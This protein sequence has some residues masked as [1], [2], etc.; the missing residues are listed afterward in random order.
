[1]SAFESLPI[2]SEHE[3]PNSRLIYLSDSSYLGSDSSLTQ[4]L[5]SHLDPD[6]ESQDHWSCFFGFFNEV[7]DSGIPIIEPT[8]IDERDSKILGKGANMIVTSGRWGNKAVAVKRVYH[9]VSTYENAREL[10]K[11]RVK[12]LNQEL[13]MLSFLPFRSHPNIVRLLAVS[14][15]MEESGLDVLGFRPMLVVELANL[16]YPTLKALIDSGRLGPYDLS[17]KGFL[18]SD[19]IAGLEHMHRNS[20]LHGDIKTSNIL[21]FPQEGLRLTAKLTDFG[22]C[23]DNLTARKAGGTPGFVGPEYYSNSEEVVTSTSFPVAIMA[24]DV[25]AFGLVASYILLGRELSIDQ[26]GNDLGGARPVIEKSLNDMYSLSFF[27]RSDDKTTDFL[28]QMGPSIDMKNNSTFSI[29]PKAREEAVSR[30]DS[31]SE[32]IPIQQNL[33]AVEM[34][35]EERKPHWMF[36]SISKDGSEFW[37]RCTEYLP[38]TVCCI[39]AA[40]LANHHHRLNSNELAFLLELDESQKRVAR[41]R[42]FSMSTAPWLWHNMRSGNNFRSIPES[43]QERTLT[44][45]YGEIMSVEG[46]L[47]VSPSVQLLSYMLDSSIYSE[48]RKGASLARSF[49]K[50]WEVVD[51]N[52]MLILLKMQVGAGSGPNSLSG[53]LQLALNAEGITL[54]VPSIQAEIKCFVG[55]AIFKILHPA[56]VHAVPDSS[57]EVLLLDMLRLY[58]QQPYV[59]AFRQRPRPVFPAG[60]PSELIMTAVE[61][62]CVRNDGE[63]FAILASLLQ[64]LKHLISNE[65]AINMFNFAAEEGSLKLIQA[66]AHPSLKQVFN[67]VAACKLACQIP[68]LFGHPQ[69]LGLIKNGLIAEPKGWMISTLVNF[70]R[71]TF[72]GS[73]D[74][75]QTH[76]HLGM[77]LRVL[78]EDYEK[79]ETLMRSDA[80]ASIEAIPKGSRLDTVP[81]TLILGLPA[82]HCAIVSNNNHGNVDARDWHGMTPFLYTIEGC[83]VQIASMLLEAG[84]NPV[85]P[86]FKGQNALH[87]AVRTGNISM[88]RFCLEDRRILEL[89][90]ERDNAG[91]TPLLTAVNQGHIDISKRLMDVGAHLICPDFLGITL[92]QMSVRLGDPA[93]TVLLLED[94]F[95]RNHELTK[96][97]C[98]VKNNLGRNVLHEIADIP[99]AP[100]SATESTSGGYWQLLIEWVLGM[101][102]GTVPENLLVPDVVGLA[103]LD[104][105]RLQEMQYL[106]SKLISDY[107]DSS[108]HCNITFIGDRSGSFAVLKSDPVRFTKEV[109]DNP[110]IFAQADFCCQVAYSYYD[111]LDINLSA[112][113][114]ADAVFAHGARHLARLS[115]GEYSRQLETI[116]AAFE[117]RCMAFEPSQV[118]GSPYDTI[119]TASKLEVC[120]STFLGRCSLL[121]FAQER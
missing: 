120:Q 106:E 64:T 118:E 3:L 90:N 101:F 44:K 31:M 19:I 89:I 57:Y 70:V 50:K 59:A 30:L 65:D 66:L 98:R 56:M 38:A 104:I 103:P 14:W 39:P 15:E 74:H 53:V 40:L 61:L 2:A 21:I 82:L 63:S 76:S 22:S 51:A 72:F 8:S 83:E 20:I 48:R 36:R 47:D 29:F 88:V 43:M 95:N 87:I 11:A 68:A 28:G 96:Y 5:K 1:M 23:N 121:G 91:F 111:I 26:L 27:G 17:L 24:R 52:R 13:K 78:E 80:L 71:F 94:L 62:Q 73:R 6:S 35:Q 102:E 97:L 46:Q 110:G 114:A 77:A 45:L 107:D 9:G 42:P 49:A 55:D 33:E 10:A 4:Q 115:V 86:N 85:I 7:M 34:F 79:L 100:D 99:V 119:G 84:C 69:C 18:I 16:E 37:V 12:A 93:K 58:Y 60:T 116:L 41:A 113:I 117:R 67:S 81:Q 54:S 92:L 75:D 108:T 25:Y 32:P 105:A 109:L 112:H